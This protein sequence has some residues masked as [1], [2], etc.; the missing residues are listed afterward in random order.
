[1]SL[2]SPFLRLQGKEIGVESMAALLLAY[3]E[4][5]D[6]QGVI[7]GDGMSVSVAGFGP[8]SEP[9]PRPHE[10]LVQDFLGARR[11]LA[12]KTKFQEAPA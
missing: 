9:D 4:W 7:K 11:V 10:V 8:V 5:L 1:M 12:F 2:D 6:T 3:S